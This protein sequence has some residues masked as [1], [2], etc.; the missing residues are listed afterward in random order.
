MASRVAQF[1]HPAWLTAASTL[2]G[3]GLILLVL[4][5]LLFVV[6]YLALALS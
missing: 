1:D 5:V 4:F 2:A 3:Y 6:P